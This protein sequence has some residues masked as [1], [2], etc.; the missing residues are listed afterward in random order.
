MP[1]SKMAAKLRIGMA[2][3]L[4]M[5]LSGELGSRFAFNYRSLHRCVTIVSHSKSKFIILDI[6]FLVNLASEFYVGYSL[7]NSVTTIL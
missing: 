6:V 3:S 2:I 7:T 5:H 4:E 1:V